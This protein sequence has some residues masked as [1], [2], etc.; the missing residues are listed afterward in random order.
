MIAW[1]IAMSDLQGEGLTQQVAFY[2]VENPIWDAVYY[3]NR[4]GGRV[5]FVVCFFETNAYDLYK[6]ALWK[7]L[8]V[9]ICHYEKK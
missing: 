6:L 5:H 7:A 3:R 4:F 8:K 1:L 2:P 9:E